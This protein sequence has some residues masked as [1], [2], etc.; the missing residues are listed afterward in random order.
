[1][2]TESHLGEP[3]EDVART[4]TAT[5]VVLTPREVEIIDL[6]AM[7]LSNRQ[8]AEQLRLSDPTILDDMES[9]CL[10][11]GAHSKV[12]AVVLAIAEGIIAVPDIRVDIRD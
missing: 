8:I 5:T 6:A 1:M 7:G 11:L 2:T 10:K 4:P 12:Q 3:G 9:I